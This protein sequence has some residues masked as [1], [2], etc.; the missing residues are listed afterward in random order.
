M[1]SILSRRAFMGLKRALEQ[2]ENV[3]ERGIMTGLDPYTPSL[4]EKEISHLLRRTMF[5]VTPNDVAVFKGMNASQA[6]DLLLKT[7]PAP[8]PPINNYDESYQDYVGTNDQDKKLVT[9]N[10]PEKPD[11]YVKLGE[12]FVGAKYDDNTEYHRNM[13]MKG[14]WMN[15]I[16]NQAPN[17]H[18]K[19]LFFWHNHVPIQMLLVYNASFSYKYYS[20]IRTNA[21]GNF[22][23]LM[24]EL[25]LDPAMLFYLNGT[26]NEKW[27]PDENYGRELQEL[28]CFGKGPGSKYT[29]DD[30]KAA[31][32]ILTG[33][34][35]QYDLPIT[36]FKADVHDTGDKQFSAFYGNKK[37]TGQTGDNGKKELDEMLDMMFSVDE[38]GMHVCRK[39]Y[40][41]F[42]YAQ[43]D[44]ATEA[45]IIKPLADLFKKSNFEIMPVLAKLLKSEHFFDSLNRGV[46][47]KTPVEFVA[48]ICRNFK[49]KLPKSTDYA[50]SYLTFAS[51]YYWTSDM[52]LGIGDPPNVAGWPAWYQKPA[53]D[54]YW[55][56]TSSLAKRGQ[57]TDTMLYW[58]YGT[59]YKHEAGI[60]AIAFTKTLKDPS[61]V[62]G[63]ISEMTARMSISVLDPTIAVQLKNILTYN[64]AQ[65]YYWTNAW[66]EYLAAPT[67]DM[68][69][70]NI[71]WRLIDFY[72]YLFQLEEYHLV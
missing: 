47:I 53:L 71:K 14:W 3:E 46:Q 25:T 62:Q 7:S 11:K 2:P 70:N 24:K 35:S 31:A 60:D 20:T 29:E 49:V 8:A 55:I 30:V 17:I 58:G 69:I 42:V 10:I 37:I 57:N 36:Y 54:R 26:Y 18:E 65:E 68:K 33:W 27:A 61:S 56:N 59:W 43:I 21:L 72:R 41:F 48:D 50:N 9:L 28:F 64:Q 51:M 22:K 5:G 6:V 52:L 15:N 23:T 19:M 45:T 38:L 13:S 16:I 39:L 34:K 4:N 67:D 32:R 1:P 66:N 12:T 40:R 63:L 44:A